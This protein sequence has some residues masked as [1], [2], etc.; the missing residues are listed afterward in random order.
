MVVL[1]L[2]KIIIR[3]AIT[4]FLDIKSYI[5]MRACFDTADFDLT[6]IAKMKVFDKTPTFKGAHS[7]FFN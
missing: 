6:L 3:P 5:I 4:M 2:A 7:V 1:T